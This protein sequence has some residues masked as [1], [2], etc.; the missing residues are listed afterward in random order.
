M[1]VSAIEAAIA[2]EW[3]E[4]IHLLE[5]VHL[6]FPDLTIGEVVHSAAKLGSGAWDPWDV[7]PG[8]VVAGLRKMLALPPDTQWNAVGPS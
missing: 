4:V 2:E 3:E 6:H 7:G 8:R 5:K 1:S